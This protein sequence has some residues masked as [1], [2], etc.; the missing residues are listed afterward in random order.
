ML[1]ESRLLIS[2][3]RR[4]VTG[5][6]EIVV[7]DVD[8][9]RVYALSRV[10]S[11]TALAWEGMQKDPA[12]QEAMPEEVKKRF[13]ADYLRTVFEDTQ[14][15]Y[16]KKNL[17]ESLLKAGIPHVFLKGSRLKYDYPVP[18][19]RTMCDMDILVNTAD[20]D[21]I[22]EIAVGMGGKSYYG[23]GNHHNFGFPAKVAVEFHPNLVHPGTLLGTELNPGWQY[24]VKNEETGA[25]EMTPEGMYL[26]T[27]GHLAEHFMSGGVGIRFVLDIWV[28]R[29][30][31]KP[32]DWAFVEKELDRMSL[33]EF[34][35]KIEALAEYWFGTGEQTPLMEELAEYII[36]SGSH[37]RSKRSML[38]AVSLSQGGNRASALWHKIFYPKRELETRYPWAEGKPW[39]LP[40][41]WCARAWGAVTKRGHLVKKWAKGTGEVSREEAE[42][43][44]AKME[45]FGIKRKK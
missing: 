7:A 3:L 22:T 21:A 39:L 13:S 14:F 24:A 40:A 12:V 36:T 41:A 38:N 34:A 17:R 31:S 10:H 1:Q 18:A 28:L 45:R 15:E 37:G 11:I 19:L 44:R 27:L 30:R 43:Q 20:Y 8:W 29:N 2:A 16:I 5:N 6:G 4:S 26:H 9:E 32:A 33:L 25:Y 23:D 42:N 35:Q